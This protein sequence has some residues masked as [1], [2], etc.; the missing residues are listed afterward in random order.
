MVTVNKPLY[1][2]RVMAA[3]DELDRQAKKKA[4]PAKAEPAPVKKP[5]KKKGAR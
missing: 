5:A 2:S 4:R 3:M 1:R